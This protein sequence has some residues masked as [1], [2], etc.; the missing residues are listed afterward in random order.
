MELN[1]LTTP[2][3]N[4][5][6]TT[7]GTALADGTRMLTPYILTD[8]TAGSTTAN[9]TIS[10]TTASTY[11][12]SAMR[13]SPDTTGPTVTINQAGGQADPTSTSP[14]NFTVVFSE[15]TTNFATGDVT[16]SG[17]A[18]GTKTATVTGSGT[19]YNVAVTGMT[20]AAR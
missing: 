13:I 20:T 2:A 14:I 5:S 10:S 15:T 4:W 16:I 19:T 3:T 6:V 11:S 18:G 12:M 9:H 17:T 1:V 8:T 7:T